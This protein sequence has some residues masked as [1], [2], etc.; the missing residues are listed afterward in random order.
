MHGFL[1]S[2]KNS[3]MN[4]CC[5]HNTHNTLSSEWVPWRV[6]SIRRQSCKENKAQV[7]TFMIFSQAETKENLQQRDEQPWEEQRTRGHALQAF[8]GDTCKLYIDVCFCRKILSLFLQPFLWKERF[9]GVRLWAMT[10]LIRRDGES[11]LDYNTLS[12]L[13]DPFHIPH[14][15]TRITQ[16]MNDGWH[17]HY[18]LA[19]SDNYLHAS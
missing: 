7:R 13:V 8:L 15:T 18:G 6:F 9:L 5:Q 1:I 10:G 12:R 17:S 4:H 2:T 14:W 11:W 19:G 16:H 3:A